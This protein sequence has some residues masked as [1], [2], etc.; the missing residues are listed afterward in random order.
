MLSLSLSLS[1][2]PLFSI[3]TVD[4]DNSSIDE[5]QSS[6]DQAPNDTNQTTISASPPSSVRAKICGSLCGPSCIQ[7]L[8]RRQLCTDPYFSLSALKP[9]LYSLKSHVQRL[10]L[11]RQLKEHEGCVNCIHFSHGGDRL[12]SGSDDLHVVVWDWAKGRK[13]TKFE[14]GHMANVFQVRERRGGEGERESTYM[15]MY[16]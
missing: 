5:T 4:K 14:S 7:Q 10:Q 3:P 16:M 2:S 6:R 13:V 1:L 12:A 15:Y 11:E 8:A 9:N